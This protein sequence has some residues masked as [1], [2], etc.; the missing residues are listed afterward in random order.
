MNEIVEDFLS[1]ECDPFTRKLLIDA[2]VEL[3]SPMTREINLNVFNVII[4]MES[5]MV[6]IGDELDASRATQIRV[7]DFKD[8]LS[9]DPN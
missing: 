2:I 7:R 9:A 3:E 5:G 4:D 6:T 1:I 8:L